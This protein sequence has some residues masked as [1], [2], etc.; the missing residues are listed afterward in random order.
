MVF[1]SCHFVDHEI[2]R[3]SHHHRKLHRVAFQSGAA[4]EAAMGQASN[5]SFLSLVNA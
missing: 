2:E 3:I 4:K 5:R 1:W